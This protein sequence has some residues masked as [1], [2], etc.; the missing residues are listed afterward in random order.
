MFENAVLI[1]TLIPDKKVR[2]EK[3]PPLVFDEYTFGA[4]REE[5]R[6]VSRRSRLFGRRRAAGSGQ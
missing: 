3:L 4:W 5:T 6:R 1:A 2:E